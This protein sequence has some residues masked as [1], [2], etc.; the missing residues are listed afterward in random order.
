MSKR[1]F[2]IDLNE[3]PQ[4]EQPDDEADETASSEGDDERPVLKRI[5]AEKDVDEQE[6]S[7]MNS[8]SSPENVNDED[9][10]AKGSRVPDDPKAV[11]T[12]GKEDCTTEATDDKRVD[13]DGSGQPTDRALNDDLL[14]PS[15]KRSNADEEGGV[16]AP[17]KTPVSQQVATSSDTHA[18]E[19]TRVQEGD[20]Q[21]QASP[22]SLD[23]DLG[24][25]AS[26]ATENERTTSI[27]K[28]SKVRSDLVEKD[29]A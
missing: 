17:T 13:V 27:L 8:T 18:N 14:S 10:K 6:E 20:A 29:V 5:K 26:K 28:P 21:P 7:V 4:V 2:L 22:P 25:H 16:T 19:A 23:F 24:G 3:I 12:A 9:V 11:A 1:R 15:L